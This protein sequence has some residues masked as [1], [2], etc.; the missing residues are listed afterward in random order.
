[1]IGAVAILFK[2]KVWL[3]FVGVINPS[4]IKSQ[5]WIIL[6][7]LNANTEQ[8]VCHSNN[9]KPS[10]FNFHFCTSEWDAALEGLQ[11]RQKHAGGREYRITYR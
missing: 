2:I 5:S 10:Y 1:M 11:L 4:E 6:T 8:V 9:N 7:N 3:T